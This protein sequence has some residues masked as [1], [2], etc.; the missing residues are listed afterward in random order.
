MFH[1]MLNFEMC[2]LSHYVKMLTH[3]INIYVHHHLLSS[4]S[5]DLLT[6]ISTDLY[7]L[8]FPSFKSLT[9]CRAIILDHPWSSLF[10]FLFICF[11]LL[12]NYCYSAPPHRIY[13][14]NECWL[15]FFFLIFFIKELFFSLSFIWQSS[16]P[17]FCYVWIHF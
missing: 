17:I 15:V 10:A 4:F 11:Q 1:V 9:S 14:S 3:H 16:F 12:W 8:Y 5:C 13:M 6:V 2:L 7:S